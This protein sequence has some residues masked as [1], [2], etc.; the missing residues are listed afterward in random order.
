MWHNQITSL[1]SGAF[2]GLGNLT[3]L[4]ATMHSQITRDIAMF[5]HR[6][7]HANQITSIADGAFSGLGK[8]ADMY[9]TMHCNTTE[10]LTCSHIAT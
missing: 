8:L 2:S 5:A 3:T 10:T 4:Y 1:A 7:L 6:N 9:V